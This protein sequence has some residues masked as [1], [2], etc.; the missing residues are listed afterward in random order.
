MTLKRQAPPKRSPINDEDMILAQLFKSAL[1][2]RTLQYLEAIFFNNS[3]FV[4]GDMYLTAYK[5]G[6]QDVMGFIQ[7]TMKE[8]ERAG[9][10]ITPGGDGGLS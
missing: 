2:Q 1:G 7:E 6:Q 4:Q 9:T 3:T 5:I 10:I 8:V